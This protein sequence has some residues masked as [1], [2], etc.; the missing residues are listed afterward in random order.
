MSTVIPGITNPADNP[1]PSTTTA[2]GSSAL[3]KDEFL[4]ILVAQLQNQD[5][6]Q[7]QD[8]S[9]FV[10]ELAQF[11]SLESQQNTVSDLNALM[12]GQA[13][14][15]STA[16]TAFIGKTVGYQGGNVNW[17]G[18]AGVSVDV[19]LG[20]AADK[21]SVAIANAQGQ[22]VRTLQLG[23]HGAGDL[24]VAWDGRDDKGT[25]VAAGSYTMQPAAFDASG[26]AV[27]GSL[28]TTGVVSGVTFQGGVPYLQI[29]SSLVQM[30]EVTSINERNT[31]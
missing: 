7:P 10:A 24:Q 27:S 15:N 3:G 20:S 19:N 13:T 21:V 30:S 6:T 4:K 8:S 22:V 28:S 2:T 9:Q 17:D 12:V 18:Q 16:A 25:V 14:A 26:N 31:P 11:S 5:P 23:A 29:G 1:A